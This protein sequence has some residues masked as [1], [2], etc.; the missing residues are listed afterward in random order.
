MSTIP[1]CN[2]F[3]ISQIIEQGKGVFGAVIERE[4]DVS[5]IML[6]N[7]KDEENGSEKSGIKRP[8][9]R[10]VLV[11][12]IKERLSGWETTLSPAFEKR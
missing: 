1:F 3:M 4:K 7:E 12:P 8:L 11:Q 2:L 9:P 5:D 10:L 6:D